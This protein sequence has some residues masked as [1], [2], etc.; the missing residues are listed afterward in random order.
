MMLVYLERKSGLTPRGADRADRPS[1][2]RREKPE[3]VRVIAASVAYP[4]GST[5]Q[6]CVE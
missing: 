6:H 4:P 1:K 2:P 3:V 5:R